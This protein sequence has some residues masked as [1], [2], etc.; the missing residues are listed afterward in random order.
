M[1][2][3]W[4][5]KKIFLGVVL[6]YVTRIVSKSTSHPPPPTPDYQDQ[7]PFSLAYLLINAY[8]IKTKTI[9]LNCYEKQN[10]RI[11]IT[12]VLFLEVQYNRCSFRFYLLDLHIFC[13]AFITSKEIK[14]K[15]KL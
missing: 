3:G 11:Q 2:D 1:V 6:D 14:Y 15:S 10:T 13:S 9:S 4:Q 7:D 8:D 5:V 12:R